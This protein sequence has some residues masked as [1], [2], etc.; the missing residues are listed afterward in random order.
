MKEDRIK[1]L[2]SRKDNLAITT[3]MGKVKCKDYR[4]SVAKFIEPAQ[5]VQPNKDPNNPGLTYSRPSLDPSPQIEIDYTKAK[6]NSKFKPSEKD[7]NENTGR[8]GKGPKPMKVKKDKKSEKELL[9]QQKLTL[10]NTTAAEEEKGN[11]SKAVTEN[12]PRGVIGVDAS[13]NPLKTEDVSDGKAVGN[14]LKEM[15]VNS[16]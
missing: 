4:S 12:T 2:L 9:K 11:K 3:M 14:V 5:I 8:D 16:K 15:I 1:K 7:D 13:G 6:E 10:K